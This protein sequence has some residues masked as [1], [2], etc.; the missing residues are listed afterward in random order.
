[1][2]N[3]NQIL[4]KGYKP[5]E[6]QRDV[7][8]GLQEHWF[9]STHI[10]KSKRQVGKTLMAIN[11]LL[12]TA[13]ELR[14][15]VS[16]IIEPTLNQSRNVFKTLNKAVANLPL[17]VSSNKNELTL[18][19]INGSQIL[20]K[21]AEQG[22]ALRG[23]TVSGILIIDEA[24]YIQDNFFPIVYPCRDVHQAP[25]IMI[26]TPR[27]KT[28][29]FYETYLRGLNDEKDIYVYDFNNY[30]TSKFLNPER[31]EYYRKTIPAIKFQQDYL[32]LFAEFNGSVFKDFSSCISK[33]FQQLPVMF[34]IDWGNGSDYTAIA[35][36]NTLNEVIDIVYFNDKDE[37]Q[38]I[39]Y[40]KKLVEHYKPYKIIVETNSIGNIFK[41]LLEKAI[42]QP[43]QGFNTDN[44]SKNRII[45]NL[46]VMI[47]NQQIKF[48]NIP[49]LLTELAVYEQQKTS[50]GKITF[51]APSGYHDDLIIAL[52][53]GIYNNKT[54]TY[55]YR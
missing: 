28:G 15:S 18:E 10:I 19:L 51:N 52:A 11:M 36:I 31:L 39:D 30:D 53:I 35:I 25:L 8:K 7:H 50:T 9:N 20:C 43:I 47:Q 22:E 2:K 42:K 49:E 54:V 14:N 4:V 46:Q 27:F 12:K 21:S 13:L 5:E 24:A 55:N 37:T 41:G 16:M 32:G 17:V 3:T 26:S 6:W 48:P 29:E 23:Y 34:S 1:M 44:N 38:T 45:N 33:D 40:I